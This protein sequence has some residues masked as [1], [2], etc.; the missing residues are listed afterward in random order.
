MLAKL[1]SRQLNYH[2]VLVLQ[3]VGWRLLTAG[4]VLAQK[5]HIRLT[6]LLIEVRYDVKHVFKLYGDENNNI[7]TGSQYLYLVYV[8]HS[9]NIQTVIT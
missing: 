7:N 3:H 6:K 5:C 4:Y 2:H 1:S 9:N 8:Q